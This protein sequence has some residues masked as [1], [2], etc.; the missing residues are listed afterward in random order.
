MNAFIQWAQQKGVDVNKLQQD[1]NAL[2]QALTQFMQEI[3]QQQTQMAKHGAKLNYVKQLKN[4]CP[5]GYELQYFKQGGNVDCGC[6]KKNKDG[7]KQEPKKQTAAD[8]F[9]AMKAQ[10]GKNLPTA[11]NAKDAYSNGNYYEDNRSIAD[12]IKGKKVST[13]TAS[14][15]SNKSPRQIN[16]I[17][18]KDRDTTYVETPGHDG[19]VRV[20]SR[21]ANSKDKNREEYNTLKRRFGEA[22][23]VADKR[24]N[25]GSVKK[26]G[27]GCSTTKFVKKG[28]KM[29]VGCH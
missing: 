6:V 11:P 9:K 1:P 29:K 2:E 8:K 23:S 26:A 17:I 27:I 7:G 14:M 13:V 18:S 22:K 12:R 20:K 28:N 4:Q 10:R 16:Q 3:Q 15:N 24:K 21:T 19:T 25:G 5:E